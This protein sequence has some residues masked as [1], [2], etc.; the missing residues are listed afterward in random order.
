MPRK[1]NTFCRNCGALCSM[2]VTVDDG[3]LVSVVADGK[4]SPYGAYMCVKG[5]SAIDFHN[6]AE[7]RLLC[8]RKRNADGSFA[9]IDAERALDEIAEK[10][11]ALIAEHGP[12]AVAVYHGTGAYRNVLGAQLEKSFLSAV[13]TPNLFSTM[14]ID[15]SAKWVTSGRMG[16]MA[17]GKPAFA[18]VDLAVIVG[19]NPV[20]THQTYP[21][22]PGESGSPAKAFFE[23]KKRGCCIVVV[24][25]RHNETARFAD[26]VIQP[27]PGNDAAL[28]AAVAHI[29]LRDGTYNKAFCDRFASQL[30]ELRAAVA[31]FTPELAAQR[32][33]VPVEQIELLAKWIGE[34]KRAFVGSGSGPSMSAHSNLN[35]FMIEA[36]NAL[37]GGYKRAGDRLRNPG[38]LNP[39]KVVEM[40][41]APTRSWE[42]GAKCR[43]VD[44]GKL[45]GEFP[46]ALL[47]QEILTPGP[48][49]IRALIVFGG[50]PV[51]G[52]G[53][54][55]RAVPAFEDLDL[56]V[57]L[58]ARMN[59]TAQLSHYVI[60]TSQPFERHD[61]TIP[62]DALYP[63]A[64]AQYTP[65]VVSKPAGVIDDWEFFWGVAAR[66][67]LPLTLKYW[68]YGLDFDVIADGL[69]LDME[70][71]P[72]PEA[73]LRFLCKRSTVPFDELLA[74]PS[75]VRP[76]IEPQYV[77]AA[78]EDSSSSNAGARLE[79]CPPDVADELRI[80][81]HERPDERFRYQLTCRRMLEAM[82]SAYIDATRTRR[83]YPVNWAHMNPADMAAEGI[84]DG[85]RIRIESEAGQIV[86]LVKGEEKLRR[87]VISM[88]HLFGGLSPSMNPTAQGGSY[89]GRLVS[90]LDWLEPINYMPRFSGI[91]VNVT[92]AG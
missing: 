54:P 4:A 26:L 53:D 49:R 55:A 86:A 88:S 36:V 33:D 21:F 30:D 58:D 34:A 52:L 57:S 17:S 19:N 81:L 64:F 31:P 60:A 41:V 48:D 22:G 44:I 1:A 87:G 67:E 7:N 75:G 78:K 9:G 69:P 42:R 82:N 25:P 43:T 59:E 73:M 45:Y 15:Q 91:P 56:L 61:I 18:D 79:L 38:T 14:T 6:G 35:D 90:L 16:L 3:K 28:F 74:N 24:D 37:A 85:D 39:R 63:E 13:G 12:R 50:N 89:T 8:S 5:Q 51:M 23:A 68:T 20:V 40:A 92:A 76:Q 46:T 62:G 66:M 71:K 27:L 2:E 80:V 72:E 11:S 70:T 65:P 32:A 77:M 47:P 83:K 84:A 10:L 29:L